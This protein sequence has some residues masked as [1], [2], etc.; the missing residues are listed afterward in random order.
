MLHPSSSLRPLAAALALASVLSASLTGCPFATSGLQGTAGGASSSGS[1]AGGSPATSSSSSTSSTGSSSAAGGDAGDDGCSA[2][3]EDC[4]NGVDDN[5]DGKIDCEDPQCAVQGY[6]CVAAAPSGWTVVDFTPSTQPACPAGYGGETK[7]EQAPS[8]GD[9]CACTCGAPQTNPCTQGMFSVQYGHTVCG[10]NTF[11]LTSDGSCDAI[12]GKIGHTSSTPYSDGI[13]TPLPATTVTCDA[14]AKLPALTMGASGRSCAPSGPGGMGCTGGGACQPKV[15]GGEQCI[16]AAGDM[17]CPD[18]KSFT[19]R[20]VVYAPSDIKD[21]R[22]CG[23]CA[24]SSKAASCS[25]AKLTT[26]TTSDCSGGAGVPLKIDGNCN[27]LPAGSDNQ[28]NDHFI[29]SATPNTMACGAANATVP[30]AGQVDT[31]NPTTVCCP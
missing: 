9:M 8:S 19:K 14:T 10:G 4:T 27:N 31:T 21:T 25:N 20:Y 13:G 29:Y 15:P 16:Q 26:F 12:G 2:K 24:C 3:M 17:P 7:V 1:G 18:M 30:V 5:C 6:A 28:N 22:S 23:T 11:S